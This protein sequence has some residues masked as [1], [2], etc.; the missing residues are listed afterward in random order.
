[1]DPPLVA[2]ADGRLAVPVRQATSSPMELI[3]SR[4]IDIELNQ[5]IA[6]KDPSRGSSF[7]RAPPKQGY[8]P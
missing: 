5:Q 8:G 4:W 6:A 1:M 2:D 7:H 3:L